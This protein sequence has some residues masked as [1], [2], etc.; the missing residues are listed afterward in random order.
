MVFEDYSGRI[1]LR[2]PKSLHKLLAKASE[3][4]SISLNQYL[5]SALGYYTGSLLNNHKRT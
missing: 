2:L 3:N 5:V 4:E 1:T